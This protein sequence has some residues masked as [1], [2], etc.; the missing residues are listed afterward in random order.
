MVINIKEDCKNN[1]IKNLLSNQ[2]GMALLTTLIFV[3]VLVTFGVSLLIMTSNDTKLS[4][5]QRDSTKAFY[6]AEAGIED[7][8]YQLGQSWDNW[9]DPT[10]FPQ[11]PFGSGTF[12]AEVIDNDDGD[13]DI[14][15]D[16]DGKVVITST[17]I[18]DNHRRVIEVVVG[19]LTAHPIFEYAI[20]GKGLVKLEDAVSKVEGD[21]YC[22][23]DIVNEGVTVEGTGITTGTVTGDEYFTSGTQE[24]P[25]Y[26]IDFPTLD[27]DYYRSEAQEN[28]LV[29]TGNLNIENEVYNIDGRIIYVEGNVKF[30]NSTIIGPGTIVAEGWIKLVE[31]SVCG[32]SKDTGVGLFSNSTNSTEEEPAI[33]IDTDSDVYG[34]I[35]A[36]QGY[37]KVETDSGVYGSVIGGAGSEISVKMETGSG[38]FYYDASSYI[39]LPHGDPVP[40]LVSW[41]E[42]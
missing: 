38:V 30:F 13:S 8:R 10:K 40:T 6:V 32:T 29:V 21:I 11:T 18:V 3:F 7:A 20:A 12:D 39:D 5:L 15:N 2:K 33:K 26:L 23:G 22:E 1:V 14:T 34:V 16:L 35:F 42:M 4:T 25:E 28:G 27:L 9:K 37:I 19:E 17:G 41:R 31:N 24:G 36:P